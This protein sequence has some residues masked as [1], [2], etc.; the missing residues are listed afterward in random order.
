MSTTPEKSG[1]PGHG[2][3]GLTAVLRPEDCEPLAPDV[4]LS[5]AVRLGERLREQAIDD[6]DGLFWAGFVDV[7]GSGQYQPYRLGLDLHSGSC[8]IALFLAALERVTG[9]VAGFRH[10]ALEAL[11]PLRHVS[12]GGVR[13]TRELL[14]GLTI[15]GLTGVGSIIY[16]LTRASLLL[17]EPELIEDARLLITPLTPDGICEGAG[18]DV[19]DGAAGALLG[20]LTLHEAADDLH[21]LE[22]A[23]AC[24]LYLLAGRERGAAGKRAWPTYEGRLL[25]GFSHGAAGIAY[26]L[27]RLAAATGDRSF[28]DA[29]AEATDYERS[30]YDTAAKNWPDYRTGD[31]RVFS[32]VWCHG[33]PGVGLARLGGLSLLDTPEIRTDIEAA[34][35]TTLRYALRPSDHLCCGSFGMAD[36]LFTGGLILG[37][38]Q[39]VIAARQRASFVLERA[40]E[41]GA[42]I[43]PDALPADYASPGFFVGLSGI[44]YELLRLSFPEQLPSVLRFE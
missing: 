28:L 17:D 35:E 19:T 41:S 22:L 23:R 13:S 15:G 4:A 3:G 36:I 14:R 25:T 38:S 18:F 37:R 29:A 12:A 1:K 32:A 27:V 8:G 40:R 31:Q 42:F 5:E 30:I 21:A 43:L 44:G 33:A 26:A 10:L 2:L 34:M 24:G 7:P 11:R 9:G 39:L 16:S 6:T 20:L